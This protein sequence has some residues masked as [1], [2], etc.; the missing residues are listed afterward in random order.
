[1]ALD[2]QAC[3]VWRC[4]GSVDGFD[5][6]AERVALV[7]GP[8]SVLAVARDVGQPAAAWTGDHAAS[9]YRTELR[10][11]SDA[12]ADLEDGCIEHPLRAADGPR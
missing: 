12:S 7:L 10:H 8:D 3:A 6:C 5:V 9:F 11:G 4:R 1:M 2:A